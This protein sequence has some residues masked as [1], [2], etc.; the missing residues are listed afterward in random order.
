MKSPHSQRRRFYLNDQ[1][2]EVPGEPVSPAKLR[3]LAS[4]P[5]PDDHALFCDVDGAEDRRVQD[6]SEVQIRRGDVFYSE[7]PE[8][9]HPRRI[10][11]AIN[12]QLVDAPAISVTGTQLR[13]LTDPAVPATDRLYRDIDGSHDERVGNNE[14]VTLRHGAEFYSVS[15]FFIVVNGREKTRDDIEDRDL[16][17]AEIVELAFESPPTGPQVMFTVTYRTGPEGGGRGILVEGESV[18]AKK[19]MVFN[20]TAT[21]K[22]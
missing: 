19:G 2:L 12:D 14:V 20:V 15:P 5:I 1:R 18:R 8:G 16:T 10:M 4:P 3:R 13:E 11:I 21:D 17:F 22:S 9:A 6:G 7:G